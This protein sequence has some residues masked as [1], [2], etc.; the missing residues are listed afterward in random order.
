MTKFPFFCKRMI[1]TYDLHLN[2]SRLQM[3]FIN[4]FY[5][6]QILTLLKNKKHLFIF[7]IKGPKGAWKLSLFLNTTQH[8][9]FQ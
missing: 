7:K 2:S 1:Y 9:F 4:C 8:F 6:F 5:Y 3:T